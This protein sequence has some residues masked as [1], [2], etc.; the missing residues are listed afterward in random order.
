MGLADKNL[1]DD[2]VNHWR[3]PSD[4]Y[5]SFTLIDRMNHNHLVRGKLADNSFYSVAVCL[6]LAN[7]S[8]LERLFFNQ[9]AVSP[10]GIYRLR[11]CKNGE[12]QS[13]TVDDLLPCEPLAKPKFA[14]SSAHEIWINL[15]QKAYAK[16]HKQY[17]NLHELEVSNVFNDLTGCPTYIEEL[18]HPDFRKSV[19][20]HLRQRHIVAFYDVEEKEFDEDEFIPLKNYAYPLLAIEEDEGRPYYKLLSHSHEKI[21]L[22]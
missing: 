13:V 18:S 9:N 8:L 10:Q 4:I 6:T 22:S 14:S 11:L 7:Q 17:L 1:I 20:E 3:R 15:L 5:E 2:T 12:W 16:L 19:A 21:E